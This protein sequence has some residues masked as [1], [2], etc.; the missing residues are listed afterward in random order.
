MK[1]YRTQLQ[2]RATSAE[3]KGTISLENLEFLNSLKN[4]SVES[5]PCL[6]HGF[7]GRG[8]IFCFYEHS[9]LEMHI[10]F[11]SQWNLIICPPETN[12]STTVIS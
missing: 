10:N 1:Y 7:V 4:G 6:F 5:L 3:M 2:Y 9:R 8:D 12:D 11:G